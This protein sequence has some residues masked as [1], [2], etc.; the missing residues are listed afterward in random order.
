MHGWW[1]RKPIIMACACPTKRN[2]Q[3][4]YDAGFRIIISLIDERE[5]A[6]LYDRCKVIDMGFIRYSIPVGEGRLPTIGQI[7]QFLQLV[8]QGSENRKVIVHCQNGDQRTGAMAMA[9]WEAFGCSADDARAE[10]YRRKQAPVDFVRMDVPASLT[11]T[12]REGWKNENPGSQGDRKA[13]G[14]GYPNRP[15]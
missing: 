2:L 9:Y 10:V 11:C 12:Q 4:L 14:C 3:Y 7:E 6:P 5:D 8:R 1:I 15:D 13:L